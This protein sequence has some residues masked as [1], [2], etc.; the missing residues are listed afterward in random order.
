[1]EQI[2]DELIIES[3]YNCYYSAMQTLH[4]KDDFVANVAG[5]NKKISY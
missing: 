3:F 5:G 1:M 4:L 2:F